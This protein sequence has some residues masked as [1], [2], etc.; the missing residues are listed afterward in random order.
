MA[1]FI[2]IRRRLETLFDELDENDDFDLIAIP[3]NLE[4]F[5]IKDLVY[6]ERS[7][8]RIFCMLLFI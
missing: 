3:T 7:L 6:A 4:Y 8:F 5:S 2:Q 1:A